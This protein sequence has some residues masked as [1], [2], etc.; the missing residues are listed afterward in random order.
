MVRT[1]ELNVWK[2]QYFENNFIKTCK[3]TFIEA[4]VV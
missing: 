1:K 3:N 2:K 4:W